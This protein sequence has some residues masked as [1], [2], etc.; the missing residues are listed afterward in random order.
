MTSIRKFVYAALLG[1][2]ALHF[3]ATASAEEPSRGRFIL[4]HD[5]RWEYATVPAGEYSFS[6]DP[7]SVSPVL[8]IT[9]TKGTPGSFMLLIATREDRKT[10]DSNVLVI[11]NSV[12]GRYVST[13]NLPESGVTLRFWAP[14]MAEKEMAKAESPASTS[15]Q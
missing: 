11:E 10:K 2:T 4:T 9:R 15:G 8:T 14:R 5:V 1:A 6:Y 3:A 12:A 7:N 13:M